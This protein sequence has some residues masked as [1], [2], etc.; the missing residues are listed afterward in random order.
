MKEPAMSAQSTL[1]RFNE[2]KIDETFARFDQGNKPGVAVAIAIGGIPVYRKGFGLASME[3]PILLSPTM[4]MRIGSTTKHFACLAYMLLCEEGIASP[5][6]VVEKHIPEINAV[7]HGVTMR[8]LMGHTSGLRDILA[9]TMYLHGTGVRITDKEMIAYYETID[10]IDFEPGTSWSY[11]NGGFMLLTAAIERLTGQTLDEVLQTRIFQPVGMNSTML[12]RWDSDFVFNSATLHNINKSGQYTRDYMGM[13]ISGAG[14]MV[15]TMDDMLV[16]LKHM[17]APV[18]GSAQTWRAI[19][20]P[21]LL[22]SGHSTGYGLGLMTLSYRG[23]EIVTHGGSVMGGNSQMIKVPSAALD[24]SLAVNRAD[25]SAM[26][27]TNQIID[28]LVDGL[29]DEEPKSSAEKT[30]GVYLSPSSGRVVELSVKDDAQLLSVDG[31]SGLPVQPD[32]AGILQLPPPYRFLQT[33]FMADGDTGTLI[34]FAHKDPMR[35]VET[36]S[37]AKLDPYVGVYRADTIGA[38]AEIVDSDAGP[39]LLF[40]GRYGATCYTLASVTDRIWR[41][42]AL[43]SL[44]GISAVITVDPDGSGFDLSASRLAHVRFTRV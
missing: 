7:A 6:D 35:R 1:L 42:T 2:K 3:L 22:T 31:G 10:D 32:E 13:E 19:R 11:N 4:R 8:Q 29:Q 39:R 12:R 33:C 5:D 44:D 41:A 28:L 21:Q 40:T 38:K 17:D 14:G 9:I 34:D 18:V 36:V 24:I 30:T 25:A 26:A 16:W 27:L 20:E 37:D 43:S 23:V 15:S